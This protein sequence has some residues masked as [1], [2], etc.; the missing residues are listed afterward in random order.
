MGDGATWQWSYV[1]CDDD[2][3]VDCTA[4]YHICHYLRAWAYQPGRESGAAVEVTCVLTTNGPADVWLNGAARASPRAFPSSDPAQRP[5]PG[6]AGGR[7]KR[8]PGALRRGG[9][10]RV[11]LM[12]MALRIGRC[13][14][15]ETFVSVPTS[16][17]GRGSPPDRRERDRGGLSG[18]RCVRVGRRD[19][20]ALARGPGRTGRTDRAPP[21]TDRAGSIRRARPTVS[22]GQRRPSGMPYQVPEG[23]YRSF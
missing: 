22:A 2:H 11:S 14:L 15:P 5:F 4:F 12:R 10:A 1:R 16:H 3:F 23:P 19:H 8:V 17:A 6:Q 13:P 20:R 7:A 9:G 18:S 21:D